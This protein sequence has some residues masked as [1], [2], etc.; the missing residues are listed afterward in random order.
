MSLNLN[1]CIPFLLQRLSLCFCLKPPYYNTC[2]DL[3]GGGGIFERW[4]G[5]GGG[6][7]SPPSP[8]PLALCAILKLLLRLHGI[9]LGT[10]LC[11]FRE[12]LLD[13]QVCCEKAIGGV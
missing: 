8:S 3:K 12:V 6:G 10:P 1:K 7:G 2:A 13:Y 5:G 9:L 4:W 11:G